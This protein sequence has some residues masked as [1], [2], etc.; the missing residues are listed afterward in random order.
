MYEL[1][2]LPRDQRNDGQGSI[3]PKHGTGHNAVFVARNRFAVFN[4]NEQVSFIMIII[5][6][7]LFHF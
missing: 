4:K 1:Y 7:Y 6:I 5:F 2:M 3:E